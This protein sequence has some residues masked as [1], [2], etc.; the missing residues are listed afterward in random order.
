MTVDNGKNPTFIQR[1]RRLSQILS[2]E[3]LDFLALNPGPSM[4]YLTGLSFHLMERP[5]VVLFSTKSMPVII[6][7]ELEAQKLKNLPFQINAFLYGENPDDWPGVF[8][9]A[10]QTTKLDGQTVG[11]EP[12]RLRFLELRLLEEA[13]TRAIFVSAEG[14]LESLRMRKDTMEIAAMRQ[15]VLIAQTALERTIPKIKIG[16]TEQAVAAELIVQLFQGGADPELPFAPIVSGGPNGANPHATPSDRPLQNGDLLVIDWGASHNGYVADLTRTFALG[17]VESEFQRIAEVVLEA[18]TAGRMAS[19]PGVPAETVDQ[20]ARKVIENAGYGKYFIHRTGHGIGMEGHEAP[21]IRQGNCLILE[22]G[23]AFTVEPG[24]YL[25]GRGGVRIEDNIVITENGA[26][27]LS[28][29]PRQLR[30]LD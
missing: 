12:G 2:A 20:A 22:P 14:I 1:Q 15:A 28:D 17:E 8:Q 11:V 10:I 18:N 3:G 7:P 27:C 6:L 21:Y 24:I 16:M 4:A 5:V 30:V 25:P 26:E 19:R 29:L 9:E 23:M 13:A